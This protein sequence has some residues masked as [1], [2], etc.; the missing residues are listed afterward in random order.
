L[1]WTT[2]KAFY[3]ALAKP[4]LAFVLVELESNALLALP[5]DRVSTL[6]QHVVNHFADPCVCESLSLEEPSGCRLASVHFAADSDD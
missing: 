5:R 2:C 4:S 1:I 6:S 3:G